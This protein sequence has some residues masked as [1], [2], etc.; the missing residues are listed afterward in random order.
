M[1][2]HI[3]GFESGESKLFVDSYFY[4]WF[5]T[6]FDKLSPNARKVALSSSSSHCGMSLQW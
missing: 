5:L 6:C 3:E 4:F 1:D 2:K